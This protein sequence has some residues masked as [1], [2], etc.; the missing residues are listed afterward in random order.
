MVRLAPNIALLDPDL[1][2]IRLIDVIICSD[3]AANATINT[4][5]SSVIISRY[6]TTPYCKA[7]ALATIETR[8]EQPTRTHSI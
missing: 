2:N 8:G 5:E 7:R 3:M 1:P 6:L 4:C